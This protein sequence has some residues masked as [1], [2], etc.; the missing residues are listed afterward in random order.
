MP[1]PTKGF[2]ERHEITLWNDYSTVNVID[3]SLYFIVFPAQ[4]GDFVTEY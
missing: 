4:F 3:M 1:W 2:I